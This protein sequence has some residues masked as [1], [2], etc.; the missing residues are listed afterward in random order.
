M[1][2]PGVG[3]TY[4]EGEEAKPQFSSKGSEFGTCISAIARG[5]SGGLGVTGESCP[6]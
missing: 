3:K 4:W 1:K 6:H 2:G 5:R